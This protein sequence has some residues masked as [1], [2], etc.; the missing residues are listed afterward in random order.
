MDK[1]KGKYRIPSTRLQNWDYRWNGYYFVT[2]CTEN[3]EEYFGEIKNGKMHLSPIGIIADVL[4]HEI[5][6]HA[7]NVELGEFVV[8]PNHIHGIIILNNDNNIS[9][10]VETLHATS[11]RQTSQP[12]K[13]EFMSSISP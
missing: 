7:K 1:F 12:A 9:D 8:M 11:L 6:N 5:K 13:N 10:N 4:W 3:K 2:I